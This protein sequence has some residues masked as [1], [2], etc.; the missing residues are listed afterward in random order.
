MKQL[1]LT[2]ARPTIAPFPTTL[3]EPHYRGYVFGPKDA[4][5]AVARDVVQRYTR[6][7]GRP[8]EI[9][10]HPSLVE[11]VEKEAGGIP[12]IGCG[13]AL[14]VLLLGPIEW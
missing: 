10:C 3:R 13:R 12:V 6:E 9:Q 4:P 7:R 11:V 1:P 8:R 5:A 14:R 2:A